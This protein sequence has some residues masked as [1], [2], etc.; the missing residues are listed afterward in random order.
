VAL[1]LLTAAVVAF[2]AA[3][4]DPG[5]GYDAREHERYVVTL[6]GGRLPGPGDTREFFSPPLPYLLPSALV[7]AG[8]PVGLALKLGQWT[9]VASSL[10]LA[11]I[12][13]LIADRLRPGSRGVKR[14]AL[15]LLG[16][17]PVYQ[18]S[19]SFFRA[20]PLLAC[21]S[22][23][24]LLLAVRVFLDGGDD[25]AVRPRAW[26]LGAVLGLM[27][28][29]RQQGVFVI[30]AIALLALLRALA[31]PMERRRH[32]LALALS[33]SAAA[34]V[35]G[36]FYLSLWARVG[37]PLAFNKPR[38]PFSFAN[39]PAFFY[40]GT[41]DGLLFAD[42][43]RP[44]FK[45]QF[46]PTIYA[47]T[48]GDYYGY[49]L[50]YAWDA[51]NH[52]YLPPWEWEGRLRKRR[53]RPWLDTNR[54]TRAPWL[55]RVNLASLLPS[56]LL[57]LGLLGGLLRARALTRPH[58]SRPAAVAALLALATLASLVGYVALLLT[59]PYPLGTTIKS[60]YLLQVFPL[61]A[62]LGAEEAARIARRSG[63]AHRVLVAGLVAVAIHNAPALVN[64]YWSGP[65]AGAARGLEGE[66]LP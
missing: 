53:D 50:I 33:L 16:A 22:A 5:L 35:S 9:N 20:E 21:L 59:L 3:T 43:V 31:A 30:L 49:F 19:F 46:V 54:F 25:A 15:L 1:G 32:L 62:L 56:A 10:A 6:A 36:W 52:R 41:G 26:V 2:N 28:L 60:V 65:G 66:E 8:V 51:R 17:L 38:R 37:S 64:A 40:F 24:G 23:L 48:W 39:R 18:R 44:S 55:G 27:L 58:P 42:P 45:G 4:F 29:S 57:L 63:T 13:L 11:V 34:A 7:A 47:D 14:L 61:L 12:V